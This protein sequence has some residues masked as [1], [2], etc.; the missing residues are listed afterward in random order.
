MRA[1]VSLLLLL[2]CQ[3]KWEADIRKFEEEDKKSPPPQEGIVF[4]GSSSIRLWKVKEAFPDLPCVNRG[5]GGSEMAD[6]AKYADRIVT[7]HKPKVV[8]VFSGGNDINGGKTPEQVADAA[9]DL[10]KK[11][12]ASL[13]KT[14]VYFI[15]LFPNVKRAAQDE[16][17]KEVNRLVQ[18]FTK[19]DERLGYVDTRSK[20]ENSEGKAR[21][22]LLRED[23]LHMNDAGYKIW[24]EMVDGLLRESLKR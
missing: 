4:V 15:S 22:E 5:F 19:T 20:M 13:P 21:P 11:I 3:D 6:A 2:A 14:K 7:P 18:A 17:C 9:K 1:L 23:G 24:N 12:H 10:V 16:K 8:V